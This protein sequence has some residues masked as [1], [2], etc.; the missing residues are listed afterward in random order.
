MF[1]SS[2]NVL[3]KGCILLD[4]LSDLGQVPEGLRIK[5]MGERDLEVLRKWLKLVCKAVSVEEFAQ[6]I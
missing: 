1:P 4:I 5:I 6:K 3:D 2:K